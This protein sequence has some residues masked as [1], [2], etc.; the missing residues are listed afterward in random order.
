MA[1][2]FGV[3]FSIPWAAISL[4][5]REPDLRSEK[6]PA[7]FSLADFVAPLKVRS[8]RNLVGIYLG[9]FM[10]L[11]LMS[12]LIVYYMTYVL[13]RP[14]ATQ[15]VL[16]ILIVCQIISMPI[17]TRLASALG[18]NR[19]AILCACV[20]IASIAF[21]ALSPADWPAFVVYV[22]AAITGFGVC[23]SLVMPWT[24][25]ADAADV[26]YMASGKDCAG[27]FSGL[28]TFFRQLAS[29]FALF[30]VGLV[31]QLSGYL[32]PEERV[33]DGVRSIVDQAQPP[34]AQTAIRLL[35]C[36]A[37]ILLLGLVIVLAARNP[38]GREEQRLVRRHVDF[39]QGKA[40]DDVPPDVLASLKERLIG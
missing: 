7:K 13:G 1:L 37:P 3:F 10:V 20:W 16:G 25:Y 29:A 19:T 4:Y 5:F 23:G 36:V 8:F 9:A 35:L 6:A 31:L 21:I 11:D 2:C 15:V 39:L 33:V 26:G 22:Q 38:L 40:P 24:M 34:A 32:R 14:A 12:S 17:V 27:S 28:M 30:V 18:K